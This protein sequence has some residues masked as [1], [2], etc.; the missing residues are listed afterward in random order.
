M[1]AAHFRG[2]TPFRIACSGASINGV[3]GGSGPPVL[4]LQ[5][6]PQ[7]HLEWRLVAPRLADTFTVVATD[8]RGYGDS[9]KPPDGDN[10]A[11]YSKRAMAQD[12][13]EV[14]EELGFSR[15]AVAGHDRGGRVAHRMALDHAD[16]VTRVAVLDIV[17]TLTLYTTVTRAFATVYFHWFFLIQPAP[18]P[19]T[20]LGGANAEF[21]LRNFPFRNLIPDVIPEI[22][23]AEY[24]RCFADPATLHAM[25]EDYRAAASIDLEHDQADLTHK[26]DCPLLALWGERGAMHPLYDV[27]RSW[28]E[29]AASVEARALSAGHWLPEERP[30]EVSAA[31]RDFLSRPTPP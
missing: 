28:R 7:T 1:D 24:A 11:G 9:S 13:I 27:A 17:P 21:F 22:V 31:L 14:M 18:L 2:F 29:R 12:Q 15:F 6:W 3:I 25:C 4:L 20:L 5:G 23:Y 19:E 16:R 26:V 8:L 10:H 30:D